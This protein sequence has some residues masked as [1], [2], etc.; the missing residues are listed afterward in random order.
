MSNIFDGQAKY[1]GIVEDISSSGVRIS[2]V[3]ASFDDTVDMCYSVVTGLKNDLTI[4]LQPRWVQI[5]NNGMYKMIGFQINNPP[6]NWTEFVDELD[7][8]VDPFSML[9]TDQS[10]EM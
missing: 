3:P 5:T 6:S 8:S 2:K 1:V 9:V 4:T 7:Q 10:L